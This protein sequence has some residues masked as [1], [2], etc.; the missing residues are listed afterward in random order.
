[1]SNVTRGPRGVLNL[2]PA[3]AQLRTRGAA[4]SCAGRDGGSPSCEE[5]CGNG[6]RAIPFGMALRKVCPAASYS[7]TAS[8]LQYHRR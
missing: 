1:M 7:P 3:P 6:S 8:R 2:T 5:G 4:A